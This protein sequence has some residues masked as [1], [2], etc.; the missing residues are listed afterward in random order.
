MNTPN[1]LIQALLIMLS[2]LGGLSESSAQTSNFDDFLRKARQY[3]NTYLQKDTVMQMPFIGQQSEVSWYYEVQFEGDEASF[4]EEVFYGFNQK[5][6]QMICRCETEKVLIQLEKQ[7]EV[8]KKAVVGYDKAYNDFQQQYCLTRK[9]D[10]PFPKTTGKIQNI[11]SGAGSLPTASHEGLTINGRWLKAEDGHWILDL[12]GRLPDGYT[13]L[14][15]NEEHA[16]HYIKGKE[17]VLYPPEY[18][19]SW[20]RSLIKDGRFG[21]NILNSPDNNVINR[22][23]HFR[24]FPHASGVQ[25]WN[26]LFHWHDTLALESQPREAAGVVYL[27]ALS[28]EKEEQSGPL[29]M[30]KPG[31][32]WDVSYDGKA[33]VIQ[34]IST[35]N[36]GAFQLGGGIRW[37]KAIIKDPE[38]SI[39]ATY[40]WG[41]P[42]QSLQIKPEAGSFYSMTMSK[43]K[44]VPMVLPFQG[45]FPIGKVRYGKDKSG[46]PAF[47]YLRRDQNGIAAEYE[48]EL[49]LNT[50]L[51][52]F[53][54]SGV[55]D[56][57][58]NDYG[59]AASP[60]KKWVKIEYERYVKDV[61]QYEIKTGPFEL[62][63]AEASQIIMSGTYSLST[64]GEEVQNFQWK[65]TLH[66]AKAAIEMPKPQAPP[67]FSEDAYKA[68][69]IWLFSAA[70]NLM[71]QGLKAGIPFRIPEGQGAYYG[72]NAEGSELL[73]LTDDLGHDL[74]AAHRS[75]FED[76]L[77]A[78]KVLATRFSGENELNKENII[79]QDWDQPGP[80]KKPILNIHTYASA[81]RG[82]G[83][84]IGTA[85]VAYYTYDEQQPIRTTHRLNLSM[86]PS[87]AINVADQATFQF[88]H[89][90]FG[91]DA[92]DGRSFT[93]YNLKWPIL[94][95]KFHLAKVVVKDQAGN[96]VSLQ[97]NDAYTS[98]F[99]P[100]N[101][102]IPEGKWGEYT[103][104]F[105]YHELKEYTVDVPFTI[106]LG[107]YR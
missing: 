74:I 64:N 3:Q 79:M 5:G 87:L 77:N 29:K 41:E 19:P 34:N 97:E 4:L 38:G 35:P 37:D 44:P 30:L 8:W 92:K 18:A 53:E 107:K 20:K 14:S 85:K 52:G 59:I 80:K 16:L 86:Q 100:Y 102:T 12:S 66:L 33:I 1:R 26:L 94:N 15:F 99:K 40:N 47:Q 90:S 91:S 83:E 69:N 22:Q 103:I 105:I 84:I 32:K 101:L 67:M 7:A 62:P 9:I 13:F 70:G 57:Q 63:P 43:R 48:L 82:A 6:H 95:P 28:Q 81:G 46:G 68:E 75:A 49:P 24:P 55:V 76:R 104:E 93:N 89:S 73:Q 21:K 71:Q 23:N 10:Q 78:A 27:S 2:M 54:I 50:S 11:L 98:S 42:G 45:N 96:I 17:T 61:N 60:D 72:L 88:E 39:V 25:E 51:K 36:P 65:D 31:K 106:S 56:D 58:G